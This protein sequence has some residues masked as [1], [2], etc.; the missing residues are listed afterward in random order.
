MDSH[1]LLHISSDIY[2][3]ILGNC[4][5]ETY[6][7][8]DYVLMQRTCVKIDTCYVC[9]KQRDPSKLD[10]HCDTIW[11]LHPMA[12]L[13]YCNDNTFCIKKAQESY[14]YYKW[15]NKI[16]PIECSIEILKMPNQRNDII[17]WKYHG[18]I[19]RY[20]KSYDEMIISVTFNNQE[21]FFGYS[22]PLDQVLKYNKIEFNIDWKQNH[23]YTDE[24]KK[25]IENKLNYYLLV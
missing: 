4:P 20:S 11:T 9:E 2:K 1:P 15:C 24:E 16:L 18:M 14:L 12:Y 19:Y 22:L 10:V 13:F 3:K 25:E 8:V 23:F 17:D 5:R 21:F 7:G 6:N